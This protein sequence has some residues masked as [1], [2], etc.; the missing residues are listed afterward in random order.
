MSAGEITTSNQAVNTVLDYTRPLVMGILN[1]TPDSFSDGGEFFSVDSAVSHALKMSADGADIIDIGGESSRPG[2]KPVSADEELARVIPVIERIR[3]SSDI[4]ISV[5][6]TKAYVAE[7]A[8]D[9]GADI[10]NDISA[11]LFDKHMI[12]LVAERNAGYILMHMR[13]EPATMQENP[14]YDDVVDEV[15]DFLADR[16]EECVNAGVAPERLLIDP[17]IGFGKTVE[18][19]LALLANIDELTSIG[20][21]VVIGASRKSFIAQV[22]GN[23]ATQDK[24]QNRLGGSLAS[25]L[26]AV[27]HGASVVRVH[28]VAET[29]QALDILLAIQMQAP[30][31]RH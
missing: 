10:I 28:D 21:P 30:I 4:P 17:G 16:V 8:L 12:P 23:S 26:Y 1:V 20:A 31:G 24:P 25:A 11:G 2:A 7:K 15:A 14:E 29:R 13:G 19:N 5:D 3:N 27:E 22:A 9:C 6:T 18:H